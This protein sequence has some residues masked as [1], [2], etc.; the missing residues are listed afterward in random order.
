MASPDI[1]QPKTKAKINVMAICYSLLAGLAGAL[2]FLVKPTLA[3]LIALLGFCSAITAIVEILRNKKKMKWKK[4]AIIGIIFGSTQILILSYWRIDASPIPNDYTMND[5]RSASSEHNQT[6]E[7]LEALA[8]NDDY[9]MDAPAIGLSAE[10][11]NS[12]KELS[13]MFKED[14]LKAVSE[15]LQANTDKILS[16]WQSAEKGRGVFDKLDTFPEIADLTE[17]YLASIPLWLKNFKRMTLLHRIYICLQSCQGNHKVAIEE[18]IRLNSIIKKINLN[19]RSLI[20]KLVCIACFKGN[21][22]VTNFIISNPNTPHEILMLIKENMVPLS[23]EHTSLRNSI[24]FEYFIWG[25]ELEKMSR[26]SRLKYS[27]FSPL[28]LNSTLR[29]ARNFFDGWIVIT[30]DRMPVEEFKVWPNVYPNMTVQLD[31]EC[32][33]PWYYMAYNPIGSLTAGILTPAIERIF[34]QRTKLQVR[35]ELLQIVLK[36]RL[37]K[38]VSLK[39]RAY[40]DEYI[41]DL[42]N[43]KIFS[44]G[45]D[46]EA[47]TK[48]DIMLRINPEVL[49]WQS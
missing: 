1:E 19:A 17:P 46:G 37:G 30:E 38:E 43:K 3:F 49:D 36:K 28:K 4:I 29:L 31:S 18:L 34:E 26:E 25:N 40:G 24:I 47:D 39:A 21:I 27:S 15:R 12:L 2:T 8:D 22:E 35:S 13:D 23:D 5:I 33:L 16:I 6:Y 9:L 20:T 11:V 44:P 7:L 45:P 48:D 32:K 41:V 14:D 10:D 42:E